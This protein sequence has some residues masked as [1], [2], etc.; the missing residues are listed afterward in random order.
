M[1]KIKTADVYKFS[2]MIRDCGLQK[3]FKKIYDGAKGQDAE[4]VGFDAVFSLLAVMTTEDAEQR[5]Y[6]LYGDIVGKTAEEVA[7][8][9]LDAMM[10]EMEQ[11]GR[12]NNLK[13]FF[14]SAAKLI[15]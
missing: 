9:D 1:R 7:E 11:I 12:E 6:E 14:E 3:E 10:D 8:T 4:S 15:Q 5:F 2:R 13:R